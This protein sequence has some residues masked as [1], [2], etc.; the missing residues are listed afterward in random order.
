MQKANE[1]GVRKLFFCDLEETIEHLL[2]SCMLAKIVWRI[3][4]FTYNIPPP[5]NI[6]SMF[7]NCLN[8]IHKRLKLEYTHDL[9][10]LLVH[11]EL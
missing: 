5:T 1:M 2:L 11:I 8:G 7:G 4:Y 10:F 6:T 3:V 9:Y